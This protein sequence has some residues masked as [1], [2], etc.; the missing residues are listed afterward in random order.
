MSKLDDIKQQAKRDKQA[1]TV[2]RGSKFGMGGR[3]LPNAMRGWDVFV[4]PLWLDIRGE[5]WTYSKRRRYFVAW[6]WQLPK[7]ERR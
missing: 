3:R 2:L 4:H 1:V 7:R 6:F 5:D